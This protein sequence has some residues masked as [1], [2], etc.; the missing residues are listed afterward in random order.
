M[1]DFKISAVKN[2]VGGKVLYY[3][4][5]YLKIPGKPIGRFKTKEQA[6]SYAKRFEK[7]TTEA[8]EIIS[9]ILTGRAQ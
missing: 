5:Y 9:A 1:K 4:L 7:I 6:E 8:A 2:G 3:N